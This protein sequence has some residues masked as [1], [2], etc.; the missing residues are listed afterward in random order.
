MEIGRRKPLMGMFVFA[1]LIIAGIAFLAPFAWMIS[2]SL[3]PLNET[4]S[5]PP[6]W[7][8]SKVQWNNY[9]NAIKAMGYFWRYAGNS[10]F[11]CL[12]TVTGTV[13]S[14]SLAAYGFSRIEWKGRDKVFLVLLATMMVPFPVIMVPIYSLFKHLGWIGTFRPLW[15]PSFF[16]GAFNVFLLRQFFL[17]LPKDISEAARI[18]GCNEL[19]IFFRII[20]PLCKPALLVVAL[21]Q[22]M[23]TW[24]DFLGPLIFLTE[25]KD[26]TLALGLQSFQSQQGGTAWHHLMAASTLVVLPVI[27]L[28]FFAQKTFIEGIAAT[29]SKN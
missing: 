5:L 24:N 25:Q 22:F 28:F 11:L 8:P 9:P 19:E 16:A 17:G 13:A 12:M 2:T 29:G 20:L 10:L 4:M 3:K 27:V 15:V 1:L 18:D 23:A 7:L 6:R 26:F 14:S 21:F